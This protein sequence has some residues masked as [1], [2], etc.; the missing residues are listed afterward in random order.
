MPRKRIY[1]NSTDRSAAYMERLTLKGGARKNL[2]LSPEAVTAL[3]LIKSVSG[4]SKDSR[5]IN[6]LLLDEAARINEFNSGDRNKSEPKEA[7]GE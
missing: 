1:D 5:V 6:R 7:A 3:E 2:V 4:E